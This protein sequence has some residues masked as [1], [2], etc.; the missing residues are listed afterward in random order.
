MYV[1]SSVFWV[2][3]SFI[4][5]FESVDARVKFY[6]QKVTVVCVCNQRIARGKFFES[7][8]NSEIS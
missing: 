8:N 3:S 2:G 5:R 6:V 7:N 4:C 1:S